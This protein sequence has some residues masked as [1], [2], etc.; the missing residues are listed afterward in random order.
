MRTATFSNRLDRNDRR[1]DIA[2]E[3]SLN[4]NEVL[5]TVGPLGGPF[6]TVYL[7]PDQA[8]FLGLTLAHMGDVQ[9]NGGD[10]ADTWRG[11][12]P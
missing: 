11:F 9:D 1:P 3:T 8:R 6:Q 7:T 4:T 2:I 10:H 5:V 12:K